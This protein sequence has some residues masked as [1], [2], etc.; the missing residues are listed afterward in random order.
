MQPFTPFTM[1]VDF[2]T[3]KP[4]LSSCSSLPKILDLQTQAKKRCFASQLFPTSEE[5]R[6]TERAD[7]AELL[8]SV[9][10]LSAMPEGMPKG[11]VVVKQFETHKTTREDWLKIGLNEEDIIRVDL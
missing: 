5:V 1:V 9:N 7:E 3:S 4:T 11:F 6:D 10:D 2:Q 8:L